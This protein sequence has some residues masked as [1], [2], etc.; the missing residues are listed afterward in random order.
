MEG[1]TWVGERRGK[2]KGGTG[3]GMGGGRREV[4][5]A[6]RMNENMQP[7]V[8]GGRGTLQKV[9]ETWQVIDSRDSMGVTFDEMPNSGEREF[10]ESTSSR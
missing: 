3:S 2:R 7:R 10:N 5:M 6:S 1:E 4:Q 9:P 8:V